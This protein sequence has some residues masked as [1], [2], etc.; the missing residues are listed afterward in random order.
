[1]EKG[2]F[3]DLEKFTFC[4]KT[5]QAM[6][7]LIVEDTIKGQNLDILHTIYPNIKTRTE[8]GF[9]G[10]GSLVGKADGGCGSQADSYEIATRMIVWQPKIWEIFLK[11]CYTELENA[12]SVYSLKNGIDIPDFTETD[13]MNIVLQVLET[14][15]NNFWYRLFWFN[16][17][18]AATVENG[19]ILTNGTDPAYFNIIDGFWKQINAQAAE[20][21]SQR[22]VTITENEGATYAEQKLNVDNIQ[23]YLKDLVFAAPLE[24]RNLPDKFILVTQSVYDAYYQSLQGNCC[25]ESAR[26]ALINGLGDTL[27]FNGISVVPMPIWDDIILNYENTG[28]KLNNPHR[29]L[30]TAKSVLGIGV[31]E[32]NSLSNLEVW[33]EKLPKVVYVRGMGFADAKLMAPNYFTLAV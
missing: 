4:G 23:G 27:T 16:D 21:T 19:G 1:M 15:L 20:N 11:E 10:R 14:S 5:I 33:Y 32:L 26:T 30:F 13:Y 17:I 18:D 22:A 8:A 28:T 6:S 31:D 25:L 2:G 3:L 7:E 24:L 29:A 9:I 12:A